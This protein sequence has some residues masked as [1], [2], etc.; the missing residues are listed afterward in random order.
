MLAR[1]SQVLRGR[2]QERGFTLIELV[3]VAAVLA[4]LVALA[5]PSYLGARNKAAIDEANGMAQQWR[6]L[7]YGCY[8]QFLATYPTSCDSDSQ[9]GFNEQPGKYWNWTA[10]ATGAG[11]IGDVYS[12]NAVSGTLAV[13]WAS[14][15]AGLENGETYL[16]T[17]FVSGSQQGQSAATCIPNGC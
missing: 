17:M 5:L 7:A 11:I 4:L 10:S 14:L 8:L 3:V 13:S 9:I 6:S 1:L 12:A 15:N 16:V 2:H